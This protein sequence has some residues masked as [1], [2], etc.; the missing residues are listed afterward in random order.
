MAAVI[1]EEFGV[2]YSRSRVSRLL[3]V[4]KRLLPAKRRP[5]GSPR[6]VRQS[7]KSWPRTT[8]TQQHKGDWQ[9]ELSALTP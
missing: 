2:L 1:T 6:T 7:V 3:K 4:A 8:N 5:R 9:Y